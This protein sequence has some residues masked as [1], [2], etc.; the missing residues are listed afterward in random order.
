MK[1]LI[2]ILFML[3][4]LNTFS[5]SLF[6]IDHYPNVCTDTIPFADS[7]HTKTFYDMN[8][9]VRLVYLYINEERKSHGLNPLV[10]DTKLM[11]LAQKHSD[12]MAKTKRYGHSGLNYVEVITN[13]SSILNSKHKENAGCAVG[14]WMGSE[15]HRDALLD[16]DLK[17]FGIGVQEN[18]SGFFIEDG[19]RYDVKHNT[20]FTVIFDY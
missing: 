4:G 15:P 10:M 14:Q 6:E 1:S 3:L 12:Y 17:T 8:T 16:P 20:Y 11:S 19:K 7:L 5:Q 18:T 2:L 13:I 9:Y